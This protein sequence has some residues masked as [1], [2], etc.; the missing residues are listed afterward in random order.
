MD[1][2]TYTHTLHGYRDKIPQD[3]MSEI[4][5]DKLIYTYLHTSV[6]RD[7]TPQG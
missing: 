4:L 6:Y 2:H 7:D 3:L 1:Q 5:I